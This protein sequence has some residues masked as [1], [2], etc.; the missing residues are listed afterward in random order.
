M[1]YYE[2]LPADVRD[3]IN[4]AFNATAENLQ[5]QG[6]RTATDDRA[7]KLVDAIAEYVR[8]SNPDRAQC[9]AGLGE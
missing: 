1:R 3:H 2:T 7:E 6:Y 9:W 8:E 4:E 5:E